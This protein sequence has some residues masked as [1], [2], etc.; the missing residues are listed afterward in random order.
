MRGHRLPSLLALVALIA[1]L[2]PALASHACA[3]VFDGYDDCSTSLS[4]ASGVAPVTGAGVSDPVSEGFELVGHEPLFDRGM[5]AALAV[6]DGYVYVGNRTDGQPQHRNP[7]IL[8]VDARDPAAPEVVHEIGAPDAGLIGETSRELRIWPQQ[9]LLMVLN[10]GCSSLI[11]AC[12]G[13]EAMGSR[14]TFFDISG[15]KAAAPEL[16]ATY[17][18]SRTPH[19]FFLWVDPAAPDDRALL[20]FTTPTSSRTNPNMIVADISGARDGEFTETPWVAD[21]EAQTLPDSDEREDRRLHSIGVTNDGTR[22]YLAFLGAGFLVLDTSQVAANVPE[23]AIELVTP[24]EN[25]DTWDNPGEHTSVRLWNRDVAL[26]TDEVYGDA[27]DPIT[28]QDHGC[29][30]GHVRMV[31]IADETAPEVIGEYKVEENTPEY[32]ETAEGSD[33]SNTTFTSY[34]SHNPTITPDLAF[35]SWHS[36]G[37]E[38][39]STVDPTNPTRL[40]KFK[41]EPLPLVG[42]EDPALS[43]GNDKVVMW[44]YPIISDGLIYVIDLRNGLYILRYTGEGAED[45]AEI[46]F[47]EGNS[48]L[49]DALRFE[50]VGEEAPLEEEPA[51]VPTPDVPA[52][53]PAPSDVRRV[54]GEGR[55]ET[56]VGVSQAAF[57]SA[58]AAVLARADDFPDALAASGLAAELDA[59]VLL[60]PTGGLD[61]LVAEE[62][63][64]LGAS[65]AVLMGGTAALSE[66]VERD[67]ADRGVASSRIGGPERFATAGLIADEV[68]RRGG[69]VDQA[70]V[71]LGSRPDGADAWPDAVAAGNLAAV[72]RAPVL[73]TGP[74]ELPDVTASALDRVL[75]EDAPVFVAGGTAAVGEGPEAAIAARYEPRRLAGADRYGTAVAIVEEARRQGAGIDT[76]FLA[77]GAV[78]ADALVAGPAA[79]ALGGVML[80]TSPDDLDDSAATRDFLAANADSIG[81]VVLVGGTSTIS[82]R[83]SDQVQS[84]IEGG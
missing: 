40:G 67:L 3:H 75:D 59:P 13:G 73:L 25:R 39:I 49:G 76:T 33:P 77:S 36:A 84:L 19:E 81:T 24:P 32:C 51:P 52:P 14:F 27:L 35:I 16:V 22:T 1:A 64:R 65:E 56:A 17:E 74:D 68:V 15:E 9:E 37:L 54:E 79:N 55:V 82:E 48:N 69:P 29:P 26:V 2:L 28:G 21:F 60:T 41:P 63:D 80:L 66:Q 20:F 61:P 11:H 57:P 30:W 62:L 23:P 45:V 8:V 4:Q 70:V 10:F 44:S 42:T 50:P 46:D 18:P 31:D 58:D 5:N 71:A 78:F 12:V 6:H 34:A 47:L 83:V 53:A 7:G 43:L 72:G 38:A